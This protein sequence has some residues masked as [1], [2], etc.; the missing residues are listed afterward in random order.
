MNLFYLWVYNIFPVCF[1][2]LL[3]GFCDNNKSN[4]CRLPNGQIHPLC[5]EMAYDWHVNVKEKPYCENLPSR[6]PP[7][8]EPTIICKPALCEIILH[9]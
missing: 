9:E 5:S 3:Q 1:P 7:T 6:P 2:F 4:D 8:P